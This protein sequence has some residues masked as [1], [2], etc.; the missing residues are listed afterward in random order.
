[1]LLKKPY[2]VESEI[3]SIGVVFYFIVKGKY[4]VIGQT[5]AQIIKNILEENIDFEGMSSEL[6]DLLK[7][8]LS[9]DPS[10]R[11]KWDNIFAHNFFRGKEEDHFMNSCPTVVKVVKD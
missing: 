1:M 4:P 8:M 9:V 3:Y 11:I 6:E 2:V 7:K 10:N 5:P